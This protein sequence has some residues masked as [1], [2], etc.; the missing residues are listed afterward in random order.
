MRS[1]NRILALFLTSMSS[2][3]QQTWEDWEISLAQAWVRLLAAP[4]LVFH[5]VISS[6]VVSSDGGR[7]LGVLF[8]LAEP[9]KQRN[10][11][12]PPELKPNP[13][14]SWNEP[15]TQKLTARTSWIRHRGRR[16]DGPGGPF[17]SRHAQLR[18]LNHAARCLRGGLDHGG[19]HQTRRLALQP[20]PH[21]NE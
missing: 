19:R 7:R 9:A 1:P 18:A 4:R 12:P 3:K 20:P 21:S 17:R 14:P 11:K 8:F 15:Q 10:Q 2:P 16:R 6:A 5:C 13:S